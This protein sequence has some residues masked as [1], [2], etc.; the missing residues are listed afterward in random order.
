M[1][2]A[3]GRAHQLRL[4]VTRTRVNNDLVLV[5]VRWPVFTDPLDAFHLTAEDR[6]LQ[7]RDQR[8]LT[9]R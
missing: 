3:R 4:D 1:G 2:E 7:E 8:D 9:R 6:E 5:A